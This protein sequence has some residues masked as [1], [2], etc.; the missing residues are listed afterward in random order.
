MKQLPLKWRS[1]EDLLEQYG[2]QSHYEELVTTDTDGIGPAGELVFA[3]RRAAFT[4]QEKREAYLMLVH[5]VEMSDSRGDA[6]GPIRGQLNNRDWV[7]PEQAAI[8]FEFVKGQA[9]ELARVGAR[10]PVWVR[11]K[12]LTLAPNYDR[13]FD[14]WYKRVK[15]LPAHERKK[16]A[17]H[18]LTF[19][20]SREHS[21]PVA[22]GI[23]GYFYRDHE[24]QKPFGHATRFTA[25]QPKQFERAVPSIRRLNELYKAT[26]PEQWQAQA[27]AIE[28]IDPAFLIPGTVFSTLTVNWN[29]QAGMHRDSGN[30]G[31]GFSCLVAL[32]GPGEQR[33]AGRRIHHAGIRSGHRSAAR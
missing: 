30:L 11:H 8:L 15:C 22:S 20:S 24:A 18:V 14:R 10:A 27:A 28:N 4:A 13:W 33:L 7:T 31:V 9:P 23:A 29:Y 21:N 32:T 6:A 3:Y 25:E 2:D 26:C 5:A 17:A 1:A 16:E 12:V 19:I